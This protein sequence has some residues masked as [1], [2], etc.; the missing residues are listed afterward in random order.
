MT[1]TLEFPEGG[2]VLVIGCDLAEVGRIK[3]AHERNGQAFLDKVFTPAEQKYCLDKANPYPSLAA[4][5][6]AKEAVSKAFT[7]GIGAEVGLLTVEIEKGGN[8]QPV[9]NLSGNALVLLGR[10]GGK[11]VKVSLS[12]TQEL[13]MAVAVIIG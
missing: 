1:P 10:F 8:G 12:H 11:E 2:K 6:A 3:D 9:A 4:R 13:A 5:W 7:T